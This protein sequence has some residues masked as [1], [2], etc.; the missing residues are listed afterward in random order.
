VR[1][2]IAR[3]LARLVAEGAFTPLR[4]DGVLRVGYAY[5]DSG[6]AIIVA[7]VGA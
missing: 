6:D 5:P 3:A 2:V 7:H 4:R 1:F